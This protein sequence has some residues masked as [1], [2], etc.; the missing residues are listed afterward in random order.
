MRD[1]VT[2]G[3]REDVRQVLAA[4][5]RY[6]LQ[7]AGLASR[8]ATALR[9]LGATRGLFVADQ[10]VLLAGEDTPRRLVWTLTVDAQGRA[11]HGAP[12]LHAHQPTLLHLR[13]VP[14]RLAAGLPSAWGYGDAGR[15]VWQP[16]D[17]LLR[18]LAGPRVIDTH[19]AFDGP[20]PRPGE[21]SDPDAGLA[22]LIDR[23]ASPACPAGLPDAT[24]LID[25]HGAAW[26]L[27][28]YA[29]ALEPVYDEQ[30]APDGTIEQVAR[31]A[32]AITRRELD[33]RGCDAEATY[34]NAGTLGLAL[35]AST[36]RLTVTPDGRHAPLSRTTETWMSPTREF[37]HVRPVGTHDPLALAP[38]IIDPLA[39]EGPLLDVASV[40]GLH[41]LAPVERG[42]HA[43][44]T[45]ARWSAPHGGTARVDVEVSCPE[46]GQWLARAT[47]APWARCHGGA[48]N[49]TYGSRELMFSRGRT[50]SAGWS[51]TAV[52]YRGHVWEP[53]RI[54]YDGA[55]TLVFLHLSQDSCGHT[56]AL[57][58]SLAS[59]QV[60]TLPPPAC[61]PE[62]TGGD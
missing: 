35:L 21:S 48:C 24:G 46:P 42:V 37:D 60:S 3:D 29:R 51:W 50:A 12:R 53:Q 11:T 1:G 18:P 22:C 13:Y 61:E 54:D 9:R 39:P 16:V 15:L 44:R 31:T 55:D 43:T 26:A 4:A 45:H 17:L 2:I 14:R 36:D 59:G 58:L 19:G 57:Q 30:P 33:T 20:L 56:V 49:S 34:R 27:L 23:R 5:G 41:A 38:Y 28:D 10:A 47:I 62:W 40:P 52:T 7:A 32:L 6:G 8:V 25:E